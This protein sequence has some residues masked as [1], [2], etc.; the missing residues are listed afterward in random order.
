MRGVLAGN[1]A[2]RDGLRAKTS[3]GVL[4]APAHRVGPNLPNVRAEIELG[5]SLSEVTSPGGRWAHRSVKSGLLW[6]FLLGDAW[7]ILRALGG[8]YTKA[9]AAIVITTVD[10]FVFLPGVGFYHCVPGPTG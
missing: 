10:G 5:H 4:S 6:L 8:L 9:A 7:I 3:A 1:L 2:I